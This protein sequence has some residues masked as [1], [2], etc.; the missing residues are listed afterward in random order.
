VELIKPHSGLLILPFQSNK[1]SLSK[2]WLE[3]EGRCPLQETVQTG[4][5]NFRLNGQVYKQV[6]NHNWHLYKCS[7]VKCSDKNNGLT[8]HF[9]SSRGFLGCDTV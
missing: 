3:N 9:L 1:E 7:W 6:S 2:T 4:Y 5:L 8:M